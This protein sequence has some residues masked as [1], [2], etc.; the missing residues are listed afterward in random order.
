M[1]SIQPI[2]RNKSFVNRLN[3]R[4]SNCLLLPSFGIVLYV[5]LYYVATLFY[6]G[7]S[8]FHK[9]SKGFSW[10]QNYW[11]NLLNERAINGQYNAARPIGIT[12][13]IVLCIALIIFWYIFS[14]QIPFKKISG[15]LIRVSGFVS[16]VIGMLIFIGPHDLV[17]NVA[18]F[19]GLI[20]I[21][22][23]F[24]GLK[25]MRYNKLFLM[26]IFILFLIVLNNV[27][28]YGTGLLVYLP[29]VQK[30]TFLAFL[31]WIVLIN[32]Q[33]YNYSKHRI[34]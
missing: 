9:N 29:V 2:A 20:A 34:S 13:M 32:V 3:G 27:L 33:L 31:L 23:T 22:G 5:I 25:K 8:Q 17:M 15:I 6:P 18:M 10:A 19:F 1:F 21:G 30:I 28:Y 24:A 16:M 26:G 12:A 11:C 7:G 14:I 4:K